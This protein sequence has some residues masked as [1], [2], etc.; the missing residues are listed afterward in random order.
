MDNQI[1]VVRIETLSVTRLAVVT[2]PDSQ[3]LAVV[4]YFLKMD[5]LWCV[6]AMIFL[7]LGLDT[8]LKTQRESRQ[9]SRQEARRP[10]AK[11]T[12]Q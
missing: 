9:K 7:F 3:L 11:E 5:H 2:Q 8:L 10:T 4:Y 1:Q 6:P 12:G